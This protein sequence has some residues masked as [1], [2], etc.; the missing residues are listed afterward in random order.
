MTA[1]ERLAQITL[2]L[3]L[4]LAAVMVGGTVYQRISLIPDWAGALPNSVITYFRGTSAA[5]SIGRFW[6]TVLPPMAV[7]LVLALI[8]NWSVRARRWAVGLATVLFFAMLIWTAVYFVPKGVIPLMERAGEGLSPD[9]ITRMAKAWI[10]WDWFR[11]AGT[12]AMFFALAKAATA[13]VGNDP[14]VAA[15][16]SGSQ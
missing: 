2:W 6:T 16:G 7:L 13:P 9:E 11:V 10:F 5:S 1:R 8:A 15:R 4:F 14:K 12:I 3:V